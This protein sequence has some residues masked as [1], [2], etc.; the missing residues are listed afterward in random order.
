[1]RDDTAPLV[2]T[3]SLPK[4]RESPNMRSKA[5][6]CRSSDGLRSRAIA[7]RDNCKNSDSSKNTFTAI[8]LFAMNIPSYPNRRRADA[9]PQRSMTHNPPRR[10]DEGERRSS[11]PE[12]D[13]QFIAALQ[14]AEDVRTLL[15][16]CMAA[17]ARELDRQ[18]GQMALRAAEL[19]AWR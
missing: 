15:A 5:H 1:M 9:C 8:V 11:T 2:P 17:V 19:R 16:R 13:A 18:A 14:A 6:E 10:E 7:E 3:E 12:P 4:R